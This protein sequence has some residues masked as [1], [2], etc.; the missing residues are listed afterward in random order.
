MSRRERETG[1]D[2][3]PAR[4]E[5]ARRIE[6]GAWSVFEAKA[7]LSEILRLARA[8]KPQMIGARDP[9]V[10]VSGADFESLRRKP[11]LGRLLLATSPR[12][13]EVETPSRVDP[14]GDP[15]TDP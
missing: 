1:P 14:R 5:P 15:F 2:R 4:T 7:K 11:H 8:G 10:V 6:D 3:I 13:G 12:L 9:C